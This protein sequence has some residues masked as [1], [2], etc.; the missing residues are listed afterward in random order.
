MISMKRNEIWLI[1]LDPAIGAEINK[2]RPAIIIND[3]RMGRLPL[4]VIVPPTDWKDN[5]SVAPWMIKIEPDKVNNLSKVSGIDCFQIR[6]ISQTR[7]VKKIGNLSEEQMDLIS[8]AMKL[9]LKMN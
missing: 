8:F 5:Y 4:R 7:F 9:I 1:N 2:T 3:D 6:S